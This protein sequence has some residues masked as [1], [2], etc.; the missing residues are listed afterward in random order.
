LA[1]RARVPIRKG[2]WDQSR[3]DNWTHRPWVLTPSQQQRK[4]HKNPS[5]QL[6]L[7]LQEANC[8]LKTSCLKVMRMHLSRTLT[9]SQSKIIFKKMVSD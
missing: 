4:P 5:H 2:L 7:V 6:L 9:N 8:L 3:G 1:G